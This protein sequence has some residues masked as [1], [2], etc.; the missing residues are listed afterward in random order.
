LAQVCLFLDHPVN[1]TKLIID[2]ALCFIAE[3]NAERTA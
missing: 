1:V 3:N 2:I